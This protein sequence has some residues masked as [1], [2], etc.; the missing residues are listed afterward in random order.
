MRRNGP[1]IDFLNP[2]TKNFYEQKREKARSFINLL[3]V[4]KSICKCKKEENYAAESKALFN[5]SGVGTIQ[6]RNT[7]FYIFH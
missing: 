5:F 7:I 2:E 6:L 4:F 3:H 1:S